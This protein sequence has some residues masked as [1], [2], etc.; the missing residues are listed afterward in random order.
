MERLGLRRRRFT[1]IIS[2]RTGGGRTAPRLFCQRQALAGNTS[3][4]QGTNLRARRPKTITVATATPWRF[5]LDHAPNPTNPAQAALPPRTQP[6]RLRQ[7]VS[8][9]RRQ[10]AGGLHLPDFLV[11]LWAAVS[12][13]SVYTL[14]A[15]NLPDPSSIQTEQE[16]YETVK[17]Y[18]RTGTHLLYESIDPRPFRG[19]RTY[20]PARSDSRAGQG[21]DHCAGRPRLLHQHRREPPRPVARAR[22]QPARQPGAGRKLD[23]PAVGQ[24]RPDRPEGALRAVVRAQAQGSHHGDRDHAQVSRAARAKKRF[25]SGISTITS[26]ATRRT[27]SRPRRRS[28]T[29]ST[30]AI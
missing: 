3:P 27:A 16:T 21:R 20:L 23:H 10:P 22:L 15:Q 11:R 30:C 29:T 14:F 1:A 19:D 5:P 26:T 28:T 17:I 9:R 7:M 6:A 4:A 18:D 13:A 24:E 25:S 12:A 2:T 8:R